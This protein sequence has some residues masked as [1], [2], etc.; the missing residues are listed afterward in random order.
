M[1]GRRQGAEN[2]VVD[3]VSV[4]QT[5]FDDL[6]RQKEVEVVGGGLSLAWLPLVYGDR[7]PVIPHR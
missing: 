1:A 7:T 4:S 6:G 2:L 3:Q 5:T